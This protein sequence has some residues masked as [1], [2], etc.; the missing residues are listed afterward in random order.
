M[1]TTTT[2]TLLIVREMPDYF[3]EDYRSPDPQL[4]GVNL[5][6][7]TDDPDIDAA[8]R[9]LL[10]TLNDSILALNAARFPQY[11]VVSL[12]AWQVNTYWA[13]HPEE[14]RADVDDDELDL[15]G[16]EWTGECETQAEAL[17]RMIRDHLDAQVDA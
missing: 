11:N 2:T 6:E 9:A 8:Q 17:A 15:G 12:W 5:M 13:N 3:F 4:D 1:N 14:R 7:P 16:E 10:D